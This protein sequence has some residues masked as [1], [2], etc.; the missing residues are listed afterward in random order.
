MCIF[1]MLL[2]MASPTGSYKV[3]YRNKEETDSLLE[4]PELL[5]EVV[6]LHPVVLS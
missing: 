6:K 3:M 2:S 5:L 4:I 1:L